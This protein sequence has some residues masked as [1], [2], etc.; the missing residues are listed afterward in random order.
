M[1]A[2]D[3][4]KKSFCLTV[5][6]EKNLTTPHKL[7]KSISDMILEFQ[8]LD[9]SLVRCIDSQIEPV[10]ILDEVENGSIKVWLQ[11]IL[12]NIPEETIKDCEA[13]NLLETYLVRGKYLI[14]DR[15]SETEEITSLEQIEPLTG[16]LGKLAKECNFL[17]PEATAS[18]DT[19]KLISSM[20]SISKIA[21]QLPEASHF[22]YSNGDKDL[23]IS[24]VFNIPEKCIN[25]ILEKE[26]IDNEG[27]MILKVKQPDYLGNAQW[28][29]RYDGR[30]IGCNI[31]DEEWI[32]DFHLRKIDIRPGDS[33]K[34]K[35]KTRVSYDKNNEVIFEKFTIIKV[36]EVIALI[37]SEQIEMKKPLELN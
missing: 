4:S 33:L 35:M 7:F 10:F 21:G 23:D 20:N 8:E 9:K 32:A 34:V 1:E 22:T 2:K 3:I 30:Q 14:L 25:T 26:Y 12:K 15:M 6:F 37:E 27:I 11:Q 18:I 31:Q 24:K 19:V 28:I 13:E 17:I 36:L 29:F 5:S 16:E